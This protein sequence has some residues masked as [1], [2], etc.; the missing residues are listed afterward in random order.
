MMKLLSKSEAEPLMW[1]S[2]VFWMFSLVGPVVTM[3]LYGLFVWHSI[4]SYHSEGGAYMGIFLI[5][6]AAPVLGLSVVLM[7]IA[8]GNMFSAAVCSGLCAFLKA[9][10][11]TTKPAEP[12]VIENDQK[13]VHP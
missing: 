12:S 7:M 11:F 4:S 9:P 10:S 6:M 2:T 5:L 1:S 3:L 8:L 13:G